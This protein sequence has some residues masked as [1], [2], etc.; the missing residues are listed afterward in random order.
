MTLSSNQHLLGGQFADYEKEKSLEPLKNVWAVGGGK[1][2]VGKS[3]VT[4]NI[5]ICLSLMGYRVTSIDLDL[6]GANLHTCL[7]VPIPEKTLSDFLSRKVSRLE[8][9]VTSTPIPNLKIISGAQDEMGI[10]NIKQMHKNKLLSKLD[11]LDT[12]FIIFDLGA[13]T[14]YNTLD[15][16]IHSSTGILVVLPEPTSIENTYR[17]IK[18]IFHRKLK[19]VEDSLDV[20]PMIDK[21]MNSKLGSKNQ[22]P[23]DLLLEIEARNPVLGKKLIDEITKFKPK[24]IMN[25]VR[26]QADID[27][28]FSM[29]SICKKYFGIDIQ[30]VGY[31]DYDPTV[32]Q[33]VK[34]RKP[35]LVEFPQSK[36]VSNFDKIVHRLLD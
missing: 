11:T 14:T 36:L 35:L 29:K 12:D 19:L 3:L 23:F 5:S 25:Q 30:Y 18:S 26:T 22:T 33:S 13:G 24:L 1:G 6:G 21:V 2:G 10:A 16:F 7:G 34:K 28:G 31:L 8:E 32:W 15:F 4:A 20:E 27:I 9:L 17:F